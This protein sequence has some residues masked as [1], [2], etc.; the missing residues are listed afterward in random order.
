VEL[1]PDKTTITYMDLEKGDV[2]LTFSGDAPAF[3]NGKSV[4]VLLTDTSGYIRR[5]EKASVSGQTATLQTTEGD[6]TDLFVNT[7]FTL[8]TAVTDEVTRTRSGEISTVDSKG[9]IH[10]SRIAGKKADGNIEVIYDA[11]NKITTRVDGIT[12][13]DGTVRFFE[14]Q[15]DF[16]G[17][18]KTWA[19]SELSWEKGAVTTSLDG[20]F[21]FSFG[22]HETQ[23]GSLLVRKGE[24]MDFFYYLEGNMDADFLLKYRAEARETI[25]SDPIKPGYFGPYYFY[26]P[27]GPVTLPVTLRGNFNAEVILD[28]KAGLELT[29][30]FYAGMTPYLSV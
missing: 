14:N 13:V 27:V 11:G 8:S 2:T 29:G 20:R 23:I 1:D 6:M 21:Y 12:V 19:H 24:L 7:E 30:G 17:P 3:V 4:I 9:V 16:T 5:V 28:A 18:L 26:F 10:P 22:E 25:V 15:W